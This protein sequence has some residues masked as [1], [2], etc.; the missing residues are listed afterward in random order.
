MEYISVKSNI[1]PDTQKLSELKTETETAKRKKISEKNFI[2]WVWNRRP[3]GSLL[4]LGYA[5]RFDAQAQEDITTC[6]RR[7]TK[8]VVHDCRRN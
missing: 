4:I 6:V 8:L 2:V 1:K 7:F 3:T 5:T